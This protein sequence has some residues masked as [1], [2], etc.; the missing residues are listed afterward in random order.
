[1]MKKVKKQKKCQDY[2]WYIEKLLQSK[3][4]NDIQTII[5]NYVQLFCIY[6]IGKN[7]NRKFGI[8]MDIIT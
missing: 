6:G 7:L 1:M 2:L 3:I 5:K 8:N 4:P